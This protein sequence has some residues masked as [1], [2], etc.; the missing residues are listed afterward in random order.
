MIVCPMLPNALC[1]VVACGPALQSQG[2]NA[3]ARP[4]SFGKARLN[5]AFR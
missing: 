3:G 5:P 4:G 1:A 2:R